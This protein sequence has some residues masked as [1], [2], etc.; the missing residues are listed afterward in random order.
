MSLLGVLGS[1]LPAIGSIGGSIID[2]FSQ[3]S[4]NNA[5]VQLAHEQ[6]DYQTREREAMQEYNK[7]ANQRKRY[8]EAGINPYFVMSQIDAGN[9]QA[10]S[11]VGTPTMQA[12]RFGDIMR[13]M[14]DSVGAAYQNQQMRQQTQMQE[15]GL[16]QMAVDTKYKL[17]DKLLDLLQKRVSI[18]NSKMDFKQKK[19]TLDLLDTQINQTRLDY[20]FSSK[21]MDD[22]L[23]SLTAQRKIAELD[24]KAHE[25]SNQWQ[26]FQNSMMP[27]HRAILR[28][29]IRE[30][31]S[32]VDL[33]KANAGSAVASAAL[34]DAQKNGVKIDNYQKNKLNWLI[35]EGIRLD[36]KAK[37]WDTDHPSYMDR[38]F[39]NSQ[40]FDRNTGLQTNRPN[41]SPVKPVTSSNG[42]TRW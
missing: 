34:S 3:G 30:A 18:A 21:S 35:R 2:A 32:R 4:T 29:S 31:L 39:A 19:K 37:K 20:E 26:E 41:W 11:A 17:Q 28:S 10:Q 24:V 5:N 9:S 15:L 12:P 14:G 1:V 13:A 38:F 36:N 8:K 42:T 7:P 23:A 40:S 6:M 16:Q 33:N 27:E 25:L 22:R